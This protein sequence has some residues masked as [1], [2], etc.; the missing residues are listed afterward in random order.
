MKFNILHD[1]DF[2]DGVNDGIPICIAFICIAMSY[3]GLAKISGF[4]L[5]QTLVMSIVVY[6]IPLQIIILQLFNNGLNLFTVAVIS[7]IVNFRFFLMSLT[8]LQYFK[9]QS[10][11][12][13][14][15]SLSVLAVSSFTVSHVKFTAQQVRYHLRYYLG[16][17]LTVY[18]TNFFATALGFY[19][20]VVSYNPL[21]KQVFAMALGIHFTA[22]SAMR[23][24]KIKLIIATIL[25]CV[26]MP[27]FSTVFKPEISII[28]VP[29]CVAIIGSISSKMGQS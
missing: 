15:P 5:L 11:Q 18:I 8:L 23:W 3:G 10:W 29:I 26:L 21:I 27:I 19:L 20:A 1:H 28:L 6:A 4:T 13:L 2:R 7:F 12:K 9:N 16:V 14:L 24:P 22:L 25:G 17:G